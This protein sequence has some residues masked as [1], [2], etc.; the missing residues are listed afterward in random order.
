[1]VTLKNITPVELN[2]LRQ[3]L[4]VIQINGSDAQL[5]ADLQRKLEAELQRI[6]VIMQEEDR[7]KQEGIKKIEKATKGN[8]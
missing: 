5:V 6:Q 7:T 1:M 4:N 8:S 2:L 3:S